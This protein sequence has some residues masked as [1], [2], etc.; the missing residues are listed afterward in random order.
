MK[1]MIEETEKELTILGDANTKAII[2]SLEDVLFENS[3]DSLLELTIEKPNYRHS[4]L[5][6]IIESEGLQITLFWKRDLG[7]VYHLCVLINSQ[8]LKT[9]INTLQYKGYSILN[10]RNEQGYDTILKDRY[11]QL[12]HYINI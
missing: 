10:M 3:V 9:I 2:E 8:D 6:S 7:D 4:D 5:V 12:M 11:D 1:I